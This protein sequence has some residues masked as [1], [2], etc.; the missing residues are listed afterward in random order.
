MRQPERTRCVA[1]E[2]FEGAIIYTVIYAKEIFDFHRI[3]VE[4]VSFSPE[5]ADRTRHLSREA[6]DGHKPAT[7]AVSGNKQAWRNSPD[8]VNGQRSPVIRAG[9]LTVVQPDVA[10]I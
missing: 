10:P 8:A 9:Q 1:A 4:D 2:S 7:L 6:R 5:V 3:T